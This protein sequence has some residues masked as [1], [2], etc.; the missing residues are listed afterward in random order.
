V[1]VGTLR[2]AHRTRP[3]LLPLLLL[4]LLPAPTTAHASGTSLTS[5]CV[6]TA[7]VYPPK[8][9][10][11]AVR[12]NVATDLAVRISVRVEISEDYV[13]QDA[14]IAWRQLTVSHLRRLHVVFVSE[15]LDVLMHV[16]PED[17]ATP[18]SSAS[19]SSLDGRPDVLFFLSA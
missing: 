5:N 17:F 15:D 11:A 12:A 14:P 6:F 4:L 19:S 10:P 13:G 1:A 18:S 9:Q 16:H 3:Q 2:A 7:S 8:N